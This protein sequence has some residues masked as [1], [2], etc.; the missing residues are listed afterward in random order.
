M[1]F[2][3]QLLTSWFAHWLLSKVIF[4]QA[5]SSH[6]F[7]ARL[8]F[9]VSFIAIGVIHLAKPFSLAYMI[10]G[11]LPN[12]VIWIYLTGVFEILSA[13]CLL[14][15]SIQKRTAWI[16]IAYLVAVL[17]ANINVAI[18]GLPAPGGLPSEPWYVWSRLFFQPIYIAWIYFAAI[19]K[20]RQDA[21][22]SHTHFHH[23]TS[24][25]L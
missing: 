11:I 2:F 10:D 13:V 14:F 15:P 6:R 21:V 1:A 3:V 17:P 22:T 5:L 7:K 4:K 20:Y 23:N 8:A 18:N 25:Q 16:I 12:P 24:C 19:K 9:A